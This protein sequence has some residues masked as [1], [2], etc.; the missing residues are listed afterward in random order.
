MYEN[1]SRDFFADYVTFGDP[2]PGQLKHLV[3]KW[4]FEDNV[5]SRTVDD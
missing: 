2:E 3:I 5:E 1:G 4:K